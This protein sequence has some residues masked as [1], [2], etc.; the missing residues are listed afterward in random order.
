MAGTVGLIDIA[1]SELHRRGDGTLTV[2]LLLPGFPA[3]P[4]VQHHAQMTDRPALL[5]I[6]ELHRRQADADR[7]LGLAPGD[8]S[9]IGEQ[10]DPALTDRHQALAGPGQPEQ[11]RA[12]G[13]GGRQSRLLQHG[14]CRGLCNQG[15]AHQQ[16]PHQDTNT[17]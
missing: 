8:S 6:D 17:P 2:E 12:L 9:V 16:A 14:Q 4:G 11:H 13:L 3:V 1:L 15:Q 5:G 10:H 7:H